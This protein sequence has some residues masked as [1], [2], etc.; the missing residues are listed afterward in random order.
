MNGRWVCAGPKVKALL[1][2]ELFVQRHLGWV[3]A[4][5][6]AIGVSSMVITIMHDLIEN[7]KPGHVHPLPKSKFN[8]VTGW[9]PEHRCR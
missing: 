3:P 5:Q 8:L 1:H 9:K 2:E 4:V 6:I 7:V